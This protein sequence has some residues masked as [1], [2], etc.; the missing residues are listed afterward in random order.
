MTRGGEW[1]ARQ[2]AAEVTLRRGSGALKDSRFFTGLSDPF[3]MT[4]L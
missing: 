1:D 2:F 4:R 3:G